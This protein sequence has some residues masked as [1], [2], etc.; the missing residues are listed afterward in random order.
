MTAQVTLA[1]TMPDNHILVSSHLLP[2]HP[3]ALEPLSLVRHAR[4]RQRT[5][6][7][8]ATVVWLAAMWGCAPSPPDDNPS[9]EVRAIAVLEATA[10]RR[11][12]SDGFVVRMLDR[13][14]LTI[15]ARGVALP[16]GRRS[17]NI[18]VPIVLSRY[19][20][21]L[22]PPGPE[23]HI[24]PGTSVVAAQIRSGSWMAVLSVP[25]TSSCEDSCAV[26]FD[27]EVG[28]QV[29]TGDD[30]LLVALP[31]GSATSTVSLT[32]SGKAGFQPGPLVLASSLGATTSIPLAT[33]PAMSSREGEVRVLTYALGPAI[34]SLAGI[35]PSRGPAPLSIQV[36]ALSAFALVFAWGFLTLRERLPSLPR[37]RSFKAGPGWAGPSEP[38][39]RERRSYLRRREMMLWTVGALLLLSLLLLLLNLLNPLWLL[40]QPTPRRGDLLADVTVSI[41]MLR[42][43]GLSQGSDSATISV[44]FYALG[45]DSLPDSTRVDIAIDA[46]DARFAG[47]PEALTAAGRLP[48]SHWRSSTGER[49]AVTVPRT[50]IKAAELTTA[51]L[52]PVFSTVAITALGDY[53]AALRDGTP[54]RVTIPLRGLLQHRE[55]LVGSWLHRFP[56]DGATAS[57]RLRLSNLALLSELDA[58]IPLGLVGA[59]RVRGIDAWLVQEGS[60]LQLATGVSADRRYAIAPDVALEMT[61]DLR[62]SRFQQAFLLITPILLG[63]VLGTTLG[64]VASLPEKTP[65]SVIIQT[66]GVLGT[67]AMVYFGTV[68][69]YPDLPNLFAGQGTT[70]FQLDALASW[71]LL[72]AVS[73]L[74]ARR[75]RRKRMMNATIRRGLGF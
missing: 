55:W 29:P 47:V 54:I 68:G 45:T 15:R 23:A 35:R 69:R 56:L 43:G 19:Q 27:L 7:T 34:W 18:L 60:R 71:L 20:P 42:Q 39:L 61:I 30:G 26:P 32:V 21:I 5:T 73:I 8:M 62:R 22:M 31:I 11:L 40:G 1:G 6:T 65:P 64:I 36:L 57:M 28:I 41:D 70:L 50:R 75:V 58:Q 33:L 72:A 4:A 51:L 25:D 67:L 13:H 16:A 66:T 9:E 53:Y 17:T 44:G 10:S 59:A 52:N 37:M 48:A 12:R 46:P 38:S 24:P 74:V 14:A 49:V 3:V 2:G 63:L